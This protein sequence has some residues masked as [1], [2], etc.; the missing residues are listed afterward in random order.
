M[1]SG[2]EVLLD[3]VL[4]LFESR[5]T[6]LRRRHSFSRNSARIWI[7]AGFRCE[8][9]GLHLLEHMSSF[10]SFQY[11]HILPSSKYPANPYVKIHTRELFGARLFTDEEMR[12][13]ALSCRL[14]N[15]IKSAYDPNK[16]IGVYP[17]E[18]PLDETV[19]TA[20]VDNV[21]VHIRRLQGEYRE[22]YEIIRDFV[23]D[24][25]STSL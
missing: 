6:S 17:G 3:D 2:Q 19:R 14:C 21:R 13:F 18:G 7:R 10:Y 24:C 12:I 22:A 9:C 15:S 1:E 5:V 20:L 11:D 25:E 23:R 16:A 8:Y 4:R